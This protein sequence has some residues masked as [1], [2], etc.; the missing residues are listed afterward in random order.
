MKQERTGNFCME[1][2]KRGLTNCRYDFNEDM[3]VGIWDAFHDL[4]PFVQFK[5]REKHRRVLLLV[6]L[7]G[8]TFNFTKSNNPP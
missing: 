3:R 2:G 6:T 1:R 5:K 7:H 8:K 4:V